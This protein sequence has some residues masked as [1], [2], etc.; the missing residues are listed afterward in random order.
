[1]LA[2]KHLKNINNI[3]NDFDSI[4]LTINKG[5]NTIGY[6]IYIVRT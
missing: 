2:Q 6:F 5:L 3:C 1:M 4:A